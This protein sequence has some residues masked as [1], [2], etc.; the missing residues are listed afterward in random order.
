MGTFK[1]L[2]GPS[3]PTETSTSAN[4]HISSDTEK[5]YYKSLMAHFTKE[6]LSMAKSM[7]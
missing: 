1:M 6:I 5:D 3:T 2:D 7:V 4:L